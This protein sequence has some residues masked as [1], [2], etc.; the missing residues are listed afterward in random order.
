MHKRRI[1]VH[2]YNLHAKMVEHVS[3]QSM[4]TVVNV[5]LY[6]KA[7]IAPFRLIH[8]RVIHVFH[9]VLFHVK[10]LRILQTMILRVHVKKVVQVNVRSLSKMEFCKSRL[11]H[12]GRLCDTVLSPCDSGPCSFGTCVL[13][14]ST[15]RCLCAP[16]WTG[17]QCKDG[18][19]ECLS[20]PCLNAGV[21]ID[22]INEYR[23]VC[24]T[25]FTGANCQSVVNPCDS[26]PCQNSGKKYS[27]YG[28]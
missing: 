20:N 1:L 12:L 27:R 17:I 21:C 16:G 23:C 3:I 24:L 19:N 5:L 6:I 4:V 14:G 7:A 25:G 28:K 10:Q 26:S 18:I 9:Q 8:V 22:G 2:C 11:S 15:W 13:D